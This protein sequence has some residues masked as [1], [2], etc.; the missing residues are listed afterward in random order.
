MREQ[1]L[2][3]FDLRPGWRSLVH[4]DLGVKAELVAMAICVV[5]EPSREAASSSAWGPTPMEQRTLRNDSHPCG[6][7]AATPAACPNARRQSGRDDESE[8]MASIEH[9]VDCPRLGGP[10]LGKASDASGSLIVRSPS[11]SA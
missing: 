2:Q 8:V 11:V 7:R 3:Q 1:L 9:V 4:F 5:G 10:R 6:L